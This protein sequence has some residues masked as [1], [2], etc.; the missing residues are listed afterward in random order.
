[1]PLYVYSVKEKEI[2]PPVDVED[3]VDDQKKRHLNCVFIGHVGRC[4]SLM[5]LL[6]RMNPP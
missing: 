1:M 3:E 6:C 2:S 5:S 4:I